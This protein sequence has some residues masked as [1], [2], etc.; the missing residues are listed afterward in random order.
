[1]M[2][3]LLREYVMDRFRGVRWF[4]WITGVPILWFV[5]ASGISGYWLVWDKL[6]QYIAINTTE[7][8]D[9]LPIFGEP[10]ARNFLN[11]ATLGSRF[12]TLMVFLHIAVPLFLLFVMWIHIQRNAQPK[13]NPP[14]GLAAGTLAMLVVLSFVK[15]A[16]GQGPA[17]L[18]TVPTH[19]DLD[20]FYLAVYPLLDRIPGA[21]LWMALGAGTL[22]FLVLPWLPPKRREPVAVVSLDNCNG[23]GRCVADCPFNAVVMQPR[24]DQR[25]FYEEAVVIPNLCTSC[26]ICVAACP[27]STP[28]RRIGELVTGI[29]LPQLSLQMLRETT[30]AAT[31]KLSGDGR[32]IVYGCDPGPALLPLAGPGVA[33]VSLPCIG[34]LPPPFLDFLITRKHTDGVFL[35]GC[36]EGDCDQRLG[37]EWMEERIA[38][39]RDPYLRERV[40]RDRIGK[41]WAGIAQSRELREELA[42][43]RAR[44]KLLGPLTRERPKDGVGVV[45]EEVKTQHG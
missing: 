21:V 19:L 15:P 11:P 12:F 45:A 33:V 28:F 18:D 35:T 10:I 13:V 3:H 30:L 4:A 29:D 20:W 41:F 5:F 17:N 36:R 31:A 22:L 42:A 14:W 37:I 2:V 32:V 24:T 39:V 25:P 8:L 40:P 34:M 1:M 43:F 7:W 6:A 26:G 27:S 16:I 44:L 9:A 38:G 23:C